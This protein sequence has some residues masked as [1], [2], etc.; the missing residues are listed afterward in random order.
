LVES[1]RVEGKHIVGFNLH[2]MSGGIIKKNVI[3]D[4]D[5]GIKIYNGEHNFIHHNKLCVE[6][7]S[8]IN[9]VK[10]FNANLIYD[11]ENICAAARVSKEG[12]P[13]NNSDESMIDRIKKIRKLISMPT[14]NNV[15]L[16]IDGKTDRDK[17]IAKSIAEFLMN[18]NPGFLSVHV[19]NDSMTS[20]ITDELY[21]I[22]KGGN[23]LAF[24]IVRYPYMVFRS[25]SG[26]WFPIWH[27]KVGDNEVA[28]VT[29]A[30]SGPKVKIYFKENG[31]LKFKDGIIF[32]A[33]YFYEWL[34]YI[35]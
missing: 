23:Q 8:A 21:T 3:L 5:F 16:Y 22:L 29:K 30:D 28:M 32:A 12:T 7:E 31:K 2:K 33:S 13:G 10:A 4:A 35:I 27:L 1:N 26:S 20:V 18:N 34:R 14:S 11:N 17:K 9:E 6:K 15:K 24:G 25:R 19:N